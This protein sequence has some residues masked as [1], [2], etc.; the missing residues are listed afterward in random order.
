MHN[1]RRT[2]EFS[3]S[4]YP[5]QD[6]SGVMFQVSL[7]TKSSFKHQT[8]RMIP[9]CQWMSGKNIPLLV[10]P[11]V[12]VSLHIP[13]TY[14]FTMAF[15]EGRRVPPCPHAARPQWWA[16]L[17]PFP[18]GGASSISG[19]V[20]IEEDTLRYLHIAMENGWTWSVHKWITYSTWLFP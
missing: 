11:P 18:Q 4:I 15:S 2:C 12:V 19:T 6:P 20:D 7:L 1:T 13:I 14:G 5:V 8:E 10:V 17:Q 16:M 3:N 9:S